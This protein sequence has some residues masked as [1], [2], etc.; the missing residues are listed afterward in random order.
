M[1]RLTVSFMF[2]NMFYKLTNH[3]MVFKLWL[4]SFQSFIFFFFLK[5]KKKEFNSSDE[6]TFL[7]ESEHSSLRHGTSLSSQRNKHNGH[8]TFMFRLHINSYVWI[9][10]LSSSHFLLKFLEEGSSRFTISLRDIK[11]CQKSFYDKRWY[12]V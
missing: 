10:T 3:R 2:C 7:L 12:R 11:D 5:R 6:K 9:C 1:T 4:F 8:W